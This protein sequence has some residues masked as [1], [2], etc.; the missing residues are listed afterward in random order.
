M[1]PDGNKATFTLLHNMTGV[2]DRDA[3]SKNSIPA[4][5]AQAFFRGS[6]G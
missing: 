3:P 6:K 4:F 1:Y 2:H 5:S